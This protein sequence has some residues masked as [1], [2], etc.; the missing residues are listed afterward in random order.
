MA[1][2]STSTGLSVVATVLSLIAVI[3]TG[4][5]LRVSNNQLLLSM[6]PSI[7]ITTVTEDIPA[8]ISVEDAGPGPAKIK[9]VTYFVNGLPVKDASEAVE[10]ANVPDLDVDTLELDEGDT[11]G[12]GQTEWLIECRK[13]P[14]SKKEQE[15]L[16]SFYDFLSHHV[17]IEVAFCPVLGSDCAK[18]CSVKKW[19]S[20]EAK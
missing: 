12:V 1:A 17:A 6:K 4:F 3:F 18:K 15:Q 13:K 14:R 10:V 9:S 5:Q 11:L 8:G 19:C 20:V 2:V 16:D 7:N